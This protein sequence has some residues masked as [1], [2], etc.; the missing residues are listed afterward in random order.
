MFLKDLNILG[1]DEESDGS[2]EGEEITADDVS[3]ADDTGTATLPAEEPAEG[4][5]QLKECFGVIFSNML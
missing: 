5:L 3:L 4:K 2:S 1:E